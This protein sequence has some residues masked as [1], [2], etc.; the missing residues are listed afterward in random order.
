MRE[1]INA[2]GYLGLYEFEGHFAFYPPGAFYM[3]HLDQFRDQG[4]RLVS[5][6]LYLN[7]NWS[8]E[9]GGELCL[10]DSETAQEPRVTIMPQ[11]GSL[12]CLLSE[13]TPHEVKPARRGRWTLTGWF[14]RRPL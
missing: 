7:D 1:A 10:Y 5:V 13:Q 4:E 2:A 11:G 3:R 14:R 8:P 12:V 9:E 6:V